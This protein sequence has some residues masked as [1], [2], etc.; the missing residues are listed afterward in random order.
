MNQAD[1]QFEIVSNEDDLRAL[2]HEWDDLWSR[3]HG[4]YG[5]S[6]GVCWLAWQHVA[7]PRGR[8]LCCIVHRE[9]GRVA[10]VWPLV[11]YRRLLWTYLCPLSPEAGDYTR[12]LMVDSPSSPALIAGAWRTALTRCGADFIKLPYVDEGSDLHAVASRE[13]HVMIAARTVAAFAKLRDETEWDA[14]CKTLGTMSGK[15][16]G[17]LERRLSKE[18]QL[19]VRLTEP[20]DARENAAL[21]DWILARKRAWGDRVGKRGEWLDSS[22]Y[23][24]FLVNLLCPANG[25]AMGRLFVVTLDGAP[26]AATVVGV[27]TTCVDG[28]IASFD[29]RYARFGPGSI[30]VEHVIKWAFEQRLN[31]DFGVGAERFKAYWSR[32]NITG[33]WSAQIANSRWGVFAFRSKQAVRA[34]ARR[35]ARLSGLSGGQRRGASAFVPDNPDNHDNPDSAHRLDLPMNPS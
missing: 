13:R 21:V 3:A 23:R 32:N 7:K 24:D 16:P 25:R 31:V 20:G 6:F 5:Q 34:A 14:F 8:R 33:A 2:E 15:K 35:M 27:G 22:H 29:D 1:C 18:G 12:V 10:M 17:A 9:N 11:T 28:L 26:V 4:Q 30:V 19:A